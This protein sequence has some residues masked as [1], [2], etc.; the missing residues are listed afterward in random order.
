MHG[1]PLTFLRRIILGAMFFAM[2]GIGWAAT[3]ASDPP[4]TLVGAGDIASCYDDH[5]EATAALLDDIEGTVFTLGDNAY[6]NGSQFEFAHCY[7][8]TWGRHL[9]RTRPVPGN[10]DYRT[11]DAGEYFAYFG[12]RAGDIG[13][14]WYAYDLGEWHVVALNSNCNEIGGCGDGSAQLAWLQADLA[15]HPAACTLAY[16]HHPR[17]S[18]AG[19]ENDVDLTAIWTLLYEHG[20]DV[21]LAGHDHTYERFGPQDPNGNAD[22]EQGIVQFVVGTGGANL[23]EFEEIKPNSVVRESDTF[24]VLRLTLAAGGYDWEFVPVAGE[25]FTDTGSAH[26]H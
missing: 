10:H 15:T 18:S 9:E 14:G 24:G 11:E 26:C 17:F 6:D 13:E 8:P 1:L 5:D 21:V 12:D 22:A 2:P 16:M 20:V 19:H 7:D 3:P 23:R 4:V 25:T